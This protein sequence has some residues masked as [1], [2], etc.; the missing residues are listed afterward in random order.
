MASIGGRFQWRLHSLTEEESAS[1]KH[2]MLEGTKA[3]QAAVSRLED[4]DREQAVKA[5]RVAIA[6]AERA[7]EAI[8]K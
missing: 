8:D 1:A 6:L 2:S 5:L 7:I 4:D 3:F